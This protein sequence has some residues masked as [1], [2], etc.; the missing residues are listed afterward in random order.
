MKWD[1]GVIDVCILL[2]RDALFIEKLNWSQPHDERKRT[3]SLLDAHHGPC[4]PPWADRGA[5]WLVILLFFSYP[6]G[7]ATYGHPWW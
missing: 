3:S 2:L 6:T 5:H 4:H 7:M 1:D